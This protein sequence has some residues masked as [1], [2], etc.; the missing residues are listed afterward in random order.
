MCMYVW[1]KNAI[2]TCEKFIFC[3]EKEYEWILALGSPKTYYLYIRPTLNKLNNIKTQA[4]I[5][6]SSFQLSLELYAVYMCDE[7][8]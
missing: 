6:I 1:V 5:W 3:C 2:V 7:T 4:E 8:G